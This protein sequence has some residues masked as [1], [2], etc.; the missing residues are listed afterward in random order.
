MEE[1]DNG[2]LDDGVDVSDL[3]DSAITKIFIATVSPNGQTD[4]NYTLSLLNT[5]QYYAKKQ[6]L[7]T[8]CLMK[9]DDSDYN[10]YRD[11][12][13]AIFLQNTDCNYFAMI[14]PDVA[15]NP[16][17]IE[18]MIAADKDMIVCPIPTNTY[19]WGN[20]AT[21]SGQ[22]INPNAIKSVV[23]DYKITMEKN[24]TVSDKLV[25]VTSAS[26]D[27]CMMKRAALQNLVEKCKNRQYISAS[28]N[29]SSEKTQLT[30]LFGYQ[31]IV[32]EGQSRTLINGDVTFCFLWRAIKRDIYAYV[33]APISKMSA[34]KR[35]NCL[36]VLFASVKEETGK[37]SHKET[38]GKV[39]E[40]SHKETDKEKKA[41][42]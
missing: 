11:R 3:A 32:S 8:W 36:G 41:D 1:V 40:E 4:I 30:S 16:E 19:S 39:R 12:A 20:L 2:K 22:T 42:E 29:S 38:C 21:L 7:I 27:F 37:E 10:I 17:L 24:A 26:M 31:Y 28:Y 6:I 15:W 35:D 9:A 23:T 33:D 25:K 34:E 14:T 18:D 13:I 5:V